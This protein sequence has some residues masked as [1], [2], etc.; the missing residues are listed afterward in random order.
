MK[1]K[2]TQYGDWATWVTFDVL[3]DYQVRLIFTND[4]MKSAHERL[5]STPDAGV[6]DGFVFNCKGKG[7][8]YLFLRLDAPENSVA[9]ESWHIVHRMFE[10]CGV[11]DYDD[12]I[13]AYHIDHMVEKVYEFK[14]AVKSSTTKEASDGQPVSGTSGK[15]TD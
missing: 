14:Q 2:I 13:V 12:E 7:L 9:H 4:L 15:S 8:S 3:A 5:G 10:W 11:R 1:T 6:T